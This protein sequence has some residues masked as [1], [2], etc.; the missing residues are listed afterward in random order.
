M[1]RVVRGRVAV[2]DRISAIDERRMRISRLHRNIISSR[3]H[4]NIISRRSDGHSQPVRGD[5]PADHGAGYSHTPGGPEFDEPPAN[6]PTACDRDFKLAII[7]RT[8]PRVAE[9]I[10]RCSD[11]HKLLRR[12]AAT[13]IEIGMASLGA[14]PIGV[15]NRV[16]VGILGDAENVIRGPHAPS[17]ARHDNPGCS[18]AGALPLPGNHGA[19]SKALTEESPFAKQPQT[20]W[21]IRSARVACHIAVRRTPA[22]PAPPPQ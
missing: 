21:L 22:P 1:G 6:L 8:A 19:T 20:I 14:L 18:P 3:L 12:I 9:E 16:G 11:I 17:I 4:R 10:V 5:K 7:D 15:F 2:P 13:W